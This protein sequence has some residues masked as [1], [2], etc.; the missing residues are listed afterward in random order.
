MSTF[1]LRSIL[2]GHPEGIVAHRIEDI[3]AHQALEASHSIANGVV[4]YMTHVHGA[5]GVWEHFEAVELRT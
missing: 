5:R 2:G 3:L 1:L 4:A